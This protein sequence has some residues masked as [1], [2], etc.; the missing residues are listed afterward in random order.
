MLNVDTYRVDV[1]E[2]LKESFKSVACQKFQRYL[3]EHCDAIWRNVKISLN[4]Y[5]FF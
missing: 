1:I 3:S 5:F 2:K 4:K